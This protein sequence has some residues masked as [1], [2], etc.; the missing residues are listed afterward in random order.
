[1]NRKVAM[2]KIN[3]LTFAAG[4]I[5]LMACLPAMAQVKVTFA[6]TSSF[7]A[8][9]A[10]LPA[11]TYT[12]R[13]MQDDPNAFDLQNST[14]SH[15]VLLEGRPSSKT[16]TG[17][18][19]ILFNRYGTMDYLEGVETSTGTSVDIETSKAEKIAA[20]KGPPQSHTVPAK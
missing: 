3:V 4:V 20:K 12:L 1:M 6:M 7:N 15:T 16:T 8:G 17:N 13:Q 14:G 10:K 18:P 5:T 19:V 9:G 2:K 11:G